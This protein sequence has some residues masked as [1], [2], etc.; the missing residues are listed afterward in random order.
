MTPEWYD[1]H[2]ERPENIELRM[3]RY[4]DDASADMG[5]LEAHVRSRHQIRYGSMIAFVS[6]QA[7]QWSD[8]VVSTRVNPLV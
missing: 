2:L 3:R 7:S 8:L 6:L 5:F 1:P 4:P